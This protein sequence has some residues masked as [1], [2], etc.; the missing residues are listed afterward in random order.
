M[1]CGPCLLWCCGVAG[2]A[3]SNAARCLAV[4]SPGKVQGDA[5]SRLDLAKVDKA[6]QG[7]TKRA[8]KATKESTSV[9][10]AYRSAHSTLARWHL[11]AFWWRTRGQSKK[12]SE[13]GKGGGR[14]ARE[15]PKG[16][17]RDTW[18]MAGAHKGTRICA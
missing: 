1:R 8:E 4:S 14:A 15:G 17:C 16:T 10:R 12:M 13:E 18:V 7:S 6:R 3:V 11:V 9:R 2:G 5:T